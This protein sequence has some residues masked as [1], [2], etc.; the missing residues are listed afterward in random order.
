MYM[1]RICKEESMVSKY[2]DPS[3]HSSV[4]SQMYMN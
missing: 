3:I 1:N 4:K 2:L